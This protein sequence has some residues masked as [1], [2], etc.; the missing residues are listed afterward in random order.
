MNNTSVPK[1]Y[2][3]D[4][5]RALAIVL[6][7]FFHYQLFFFGHPQWVTDVS[8]FGWTGV[9]LFFVLS[10]FL[11]SSH[12]F[13][14]IIKTGTVSIQ[15]F[16]TKRLFRIIPAYA[17]VVAVYFLV[18]SF[19]EREALPDLWRFATFTQN[20]GLD[21]RTQGTFSHAWSLC[22]EEHFYLL[23]PLILIL[24]LVTKQF[25]SA[26]WL[27]LVL[28]VAGIAIRWYCWNTFY[29]PVSDDPQ[30]GLQWYRHVYYPTYC[31]LDGLLAGVS[32]AA[33]YHFRPVLWQRLARYGN[34]LILL[35]IAVLAGSYLLVLDQVSFT[36]SVFGFP[37][38]ALGYGLLV[39]G[40]V[41]P[42][43][44]LFKWRSK[45]T[46]LIAA[47]SYSVY[48][49]HKGVI[50]ITQ[51]LTGIDRDSNLMLLACIVTTVVSAG[52]LY[53]IVEQPFIT[54][55]RKVISPS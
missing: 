12:L 19:H 26:W 1:L 44:L 40:A 55:G 32:L 41:S 39:A 27:P 43:S 16:F 51:E 33:I 48:L 11:I 42:G 38:I 18:S 23:L 6:V 49:S 10:G 34:W 15:V 14:H 22:V 36:A 13:A 54:L 9:D 28:F 2:G 3:L 4:H 35:G 7:F 50:H 25:R 17:V 31:R 8:R 47:I 5:L 53:K 30:G 46:T 24:L 52:L 45:S 29:R 21:L 20:F 37:L